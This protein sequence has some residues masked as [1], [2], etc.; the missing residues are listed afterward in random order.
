MLLQTPERHRTRRQLARLRP[1]RDFIV[2]AYACVSI[3][4]V[5]P[6]LATIAILPVVFV[7]SIATTVVDYWLGMKE[8]W[9]GSGRRGR[10]ISATRRR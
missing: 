2:G 5:P 4:F 9:I 10:E 8:A 3:V 6:L 1:A 7:G